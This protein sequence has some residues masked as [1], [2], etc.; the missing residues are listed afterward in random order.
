M[1]MSS[2]VGM[3]VYWLQWPERTE[4]TPSHFTHYYDFLPVA[5]FSDSYRYFTVVVILFNTI[6]SIQFFKALPAG[7]HLYNTLQSCTPQIVQ[8]AIFFGVICLGFAFAGW[9][10]AG[11]THYEW[12]TLDK[13]LFHVYEMNF[14]MYDAAELYDMH[15]TG[16]IFVYLSSL[17]LAVIMLNVA[18]AIIM[19]AFE[20]QKQLIQATMS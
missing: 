1:L 11:P 15:L 9:T 19:G 4:A 5:H 12:H 14:N 16:K 3:W 18:L 8:F 17:V 10:F 7:K 2:Q 20:T 6:K 13:S